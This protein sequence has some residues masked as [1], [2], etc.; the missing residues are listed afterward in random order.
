MENTTKKRSALERFLWEHKI[1]HS[2][3][4]EESGIS[5]VTIWQLLKG[6]ITEKPKRAVT[7]GLKRIAES[8]NIPFDAEEIWE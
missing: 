4:A 8:R 6:N 3:L 2:Q 1:T 5:R 7:E